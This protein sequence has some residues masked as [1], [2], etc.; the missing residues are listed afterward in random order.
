[1]SATIYR[2]GNEPRTVKNLGWLLRN[3]T[4]VQTFQLLLSPPKSRCD[5]RLVAHLRDGGQYET[6]FASL[7]V[8]WRWLNRP[9]FQTIP[10]SVHSPDGKCQTLAIGSPEWNAR[11]RTFDA[12]RTG[13]EYTVAFETFLASLA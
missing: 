12:V 6:D 7:S 13:P 2:P 9:V 5:L 3:W 10:A 8:C 1:M 4:D 11:M